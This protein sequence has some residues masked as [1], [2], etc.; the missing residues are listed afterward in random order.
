MFSEDFER[1]KNKILDPRGKIIRKWSRIF[2]AA[3]LVSLFVDPLFFFLPIVRG[4]ACIDITTP[5]KLILTIIR[6]MADIFYW[7]HIL[8]RFHTAYVAPSSRV[9][10]RG[11]IVIEPSKI[12]QRYLHKGFWLDLVAALPLPQVKIFFTSS[13]RFR[14]IKVII[15]GVVMTIVY[16]FR[17]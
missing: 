12:A 3:C 4:D 13:G 1:A 14:E 5:F 9:L 17:C 7:I 11:E 2:F 10:G 16:L 6:S 8:V 15:M